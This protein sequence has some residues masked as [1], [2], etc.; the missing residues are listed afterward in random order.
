MDGIADYRFVR[1]LGRGSHGEFFLAIPPPRLGLDVDHVGVK[2]MGGQSSEDGVR[3]AGRELQTFAQV[4]SPYLV[5]LYDAGQEDLRF[6][7]AM[8]Y[9]PLGSLA[10]PARPLR[11]AEILHAVADAARATHDL[12]E[13][14]I[15][16][17]GIKPANI[18]LTETGAKLSDLGLARALTPGQSLTGLGPV[19]AVEYLDPGL[20]RGEQGSRATDIFSLAVTLHTA[21]VGISVYGDLEGAEPLVAIRRVL[22]TRP[23]V[24]PTLGP[25][26]AELIGACLDPDP[27]L[28][29]KTAAELAARLDELAAAG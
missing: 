8:E 13:A 20:L 7:Y 21:L 29:P 9:C 2:V 10:A 24:S 14:G 5:A 28:R 6:F 27:S 22:T 25:A 18:L 11:P 16:H 23:Q 12:H 4:R 3:R 26:E 15:V 19:E 17:R 1:S